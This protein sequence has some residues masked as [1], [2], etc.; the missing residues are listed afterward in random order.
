MP[1]PPPPPPPPMGGGPP[2]PPPPPGNLPSRPPAGNRGALLSD[3]SKGKQ[4]KKAVTNDR[5]APM[6]GKVSGGSGPAPMGGAP[7][8]P[9]GL[10]P[11]GARNRARSNS[12]QSS[13]DTGGVTGTEQPPQLAGLFAG[14]MP[15][16][17][18]RGGGVD[19][20]ANR[21]SSSTSDPESSRNSAPKPPSM[22]APRPPNAAPP[23]PGYWWKCG[24]KT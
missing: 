2:A 16:L 20:G 5:S 17:K 18:K 1:P 12:D 7:P 15:K 24:S 11:P 14:G 22:A 6:I 23:L 13:R 10:K 4:L 3:I 21:D 8:V 9:G 19:T